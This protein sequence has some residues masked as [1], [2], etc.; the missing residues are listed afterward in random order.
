MPFPSS[1]FVGDRAPEKEDHHFRL[2]HAAEAARIVSGFPPGCVPLSFA[3]VCAA[4]RSKLP[5]SRN[6]WKDHVCNMLHACGLFTCKHDWK[7]E[8]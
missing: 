4:G 1:N 3:K 7:L 8:F 5:M 2:G 6:S